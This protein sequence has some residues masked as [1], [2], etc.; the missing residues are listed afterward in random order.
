[1]NSQSYSAWKSISFRERE[2]KSCL[3]RVLHFKMVNLSSMKE[4]N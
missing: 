2:T 3:F 4:V 1:L